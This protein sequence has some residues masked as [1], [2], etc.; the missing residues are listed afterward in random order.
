MIAL[1][2]RCAYLAPRQPSTRNQ[3]SSENW[4]PPRA[5]AQRPTERARDLTLCMNSDVPRPEPGHR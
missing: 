4:V 5:N 2:L 3:S 1:A